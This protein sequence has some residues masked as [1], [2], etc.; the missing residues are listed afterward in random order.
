MQAQQRFMQAGHFGMQVQVGPAP[1]E[2]LAK[3]E[4]GHIT[5]LIQDA[6]REKQRSDERKMFALKGA[7]IGGIGGFLLLCWLF[8]HYEKPELLKDILLLFTGLVG[9]FLGGLGVGKAMKKG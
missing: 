6:G 1:N 5:T 8:L 3:L 9:G 4:P 7:I 2:L